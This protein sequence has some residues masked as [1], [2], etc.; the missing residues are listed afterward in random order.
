[1]LSNYFDTIYSNNRGNMSMQIYIEELC[2]LPV[3]SDNFSIDSLILHR[4]NGSIIFKFTLSI[5]KHTHFG[6]SDVGVVISEILGFF[7]SENF[8]Q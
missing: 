5:L 3:G 1:M 4:F 8:F 2:F 7:C 6:I